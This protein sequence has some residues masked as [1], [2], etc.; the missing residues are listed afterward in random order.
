LGLNHSCQPLNFYAM[1]MT[2]SNDILANHILLN[3]PPYNPALFS[4]MIGTFLGC[5]TFSAVLP[6]FPP[7]FS[8]TFLRASPALSSALLSVL[9]T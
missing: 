9:T 8:R 6:Y 4:V 7:L 3:F 5:S 2:V 1:G